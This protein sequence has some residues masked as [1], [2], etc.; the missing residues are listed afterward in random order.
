MSDHDFEK[1]V[2]VR[3]DQ[4]K[5][6]P[7]D[8]VWTV[9]EK[10]IRREKRR[11]RMIIWLPLLLLTLGAGGYFAMQE[12]SQPATQDLVKL[13]IPSTDATKNNKPSTQTSTQTPDNSVPSTHEPV[14]PPQPNTAGN[15]TVTE[16]A[17]HEKPSTDHQPTGKEIASPMVTKTNTDRAS[18]VNNLP[19]V[20][21][22]TCW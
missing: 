2:K 22:R 11:R 21:K 6:R 1:Q 4:L 8:A 20:K 10:N 12:N 17:H 7:S 13:T 9:V 18:T 16:P 19:L 15:V 5:L 14:T 3:L